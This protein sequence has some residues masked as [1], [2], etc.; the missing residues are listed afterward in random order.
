M[1]KC[2]YNQQP[3]YA[4]SEYFTTKKQRCGKFFVLLANN[5]TM[6]H[7]LS[8]RFFSNVILKILFFFEILIYETNKQTMA[9]A[10]FSTNKNVYRSLCA[11]VF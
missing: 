5:D 11:R 9:T 6:L 2:Y 3:D 7:L 8:E 1:C 4:A 10:H